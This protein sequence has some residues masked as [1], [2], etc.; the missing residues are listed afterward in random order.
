M[1]IFRFSHQITE[2]I[3][4]AKYI[5]HQ[6]PSNTSWIFYYFM[7]ENACKNYLVET[8]DKDPYPNQTNETQNKLLKVSFY[9]NIY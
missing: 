3:I 8:E 7:K 2:L 5:K 6:V 1:N 9:A 4:L